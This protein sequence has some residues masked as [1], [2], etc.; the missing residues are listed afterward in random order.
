M[1]FNDMQIQVAP[2]GRLLLPL[3]VRRR[4]GLE[5]G[6]TLQIEIG[7]HGVVLRTRR[8]M[9]HRARALAKQHLKPFSGSLVDD[10][11]AERR[12]DAL[13]EAAKD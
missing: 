12:A 11:F 2:N 4:L 9:A 3:D 10:L 8:Q 13:Q 6:G 7:E 1:T 5:Q